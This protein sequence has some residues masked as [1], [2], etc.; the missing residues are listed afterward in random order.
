MQQKGYWFPLVTW[1]PP[2]GT[3]SAVHGALLPKLI[4]KMEHCKQC[5]KEGGV[6]WAAVHPSHWGSSSDEDLV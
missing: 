4:F 3:P 6:G 2:C 5:L 1:F